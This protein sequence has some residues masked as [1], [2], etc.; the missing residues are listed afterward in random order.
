MPKCTTCRN[1]IMQKSSGNSLKFFQCRIVIYV[2][3]NVCGK[4][5]TTYHHCGKRHDLFELPLVRL[6]RLILCSSPGG[7]CLTKNLW[8]K[9]TSIRPLR[10]TFLVAVPVSI[11]HRDLIWASWPWSSAAWF[12]VCLQLL[13]TINESVLWKKNKK[14]KRVKKGVLCH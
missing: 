14:K 7:R 1:R 3:K 6:L 8:V 11:A 9:A 13:Y 12:F 2:R 10:L 5:N 4:Q